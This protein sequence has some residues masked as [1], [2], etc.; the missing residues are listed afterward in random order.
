MRAP[1]GI[2]RLTRTA[3][4][5]VVALAGLFVASPAA[6]AHPGG[7]VPLNLVVLGDSF[8]AG[9]GTP[10]YIDSPSTCKRSDAAY[11]T[12]LASLRSITLQA[13][14]ACTGATTTDVA[15]TGSNGEPRQIDSIT[16]DT[17]LV[18]VQ[19][20][21]NDFAVGRIA[22]LCFLPDPGVTCEAG[23][24]FPAAPGTPLAG[25]TIGDIV[26]SIPT[27]GGPKL[28]ALYSAVNEKLVKRGA[29]AY[30]IGYPSLLGDGGP[31]CATSITPGELA[32]AAQMTTNLNAVIKAKAQ[33]WGL[34]FVPVERRFRGL[35]ACGPVTAI[36][37]P[38]P[39]GTS[40]AAS[41]DEQGEGA[42]HPNPLGHAIYAAAIAKRIRS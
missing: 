32:L 40:P 17:D 30:A 10:P 27:L 19:A 7:R 36:Y 35:D 42:L 23:M 3:L 2:R 5:V 11:A 26:A 34:E 25:L 24:P 8:A 9:V 39:P 16:R 29:R 15:V 37:P 21:G 14:V 12:L 31:Y 6:S 33:Q 20:L 4:A 18:T 1:R 41:A 13:F 28:D 22:R 38:L